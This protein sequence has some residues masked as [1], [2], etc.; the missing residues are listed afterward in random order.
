LDL[1][2]IHGDIK[3]SNVLLDQQGRA[4]VIDFGLAFIARY[5]K[6]KKEEMSLVGT[7]VYMSPEQILEE[8]VD[9]RSDIYSLG[10]T[11]FNMLTACF[12]SGDR[13]KAKELLEYHL[14][15]SL[16]EAQLILNEFQDIPLHIKKAILT[17]L[18]SDPNNRHQSCLEFSLAIKEDAPHEMYSELLRFSLLTKN[19]I[20][21][22][23]RSYL[24]KI[25]SRKGLAPEETKAL[26]IRMRE[27]MGLPPLDFAKEYGDAYQDL[28]ARGRE[29][30][31]VYLDKLEK[32]YLREDRISGETAKSIRTETRKNRPKH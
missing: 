30:Q 2:T 26:E 21:S 1:P 16:D 6:N 31:D 7:P 12:P 10:V 27:D 14:E 32:I 5:G 20:T 25:A 9:I 29:K 3:P 11:F 15:G 19:D 22:S 24:D 17:A 13:I 8:E 4:K 18:D 23:E 28:L